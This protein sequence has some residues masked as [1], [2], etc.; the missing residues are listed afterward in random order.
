[1]DDSMPLFLRQT[2][3]LAQS[4]H[5]AYGP[6]PCIAVLWADLTIGLRYSFL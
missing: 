2:R 3:N 5:P 4:L 1:M 6:G